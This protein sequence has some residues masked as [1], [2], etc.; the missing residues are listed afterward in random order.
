M[1]LK[2]FIIVPSAIVKWFLTRVKVPTAPGS[3]E[4]VLAISSLWVTEHQ[5]MELLDQMILMAGTKF[6]FKGL[7]MINIDKKYKTRCGYPVRNL[8]ASGL[9]YKGEYFHAGSWHLG[10]WL[11]NGNPDIPTTDLDFI[12]SLSLVEYSE[13]SV[14]RAGVQKQLKLG[15]F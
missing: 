12:S 14:K 15:G 11:C 13:I 1:E 8:H 6:R 10:G 2:P 3:V 9:A 4:F 5:L 7:V